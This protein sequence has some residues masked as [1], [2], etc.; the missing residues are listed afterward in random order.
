MAEYMVIE[1]FRAGNSAAVYAR[2]TEKGRMLPE[3]LDFVASWLSGRDDTC[4]QVMRT[5]TPES[6]D[7]WTR[8][9]D[10]LVDFEI[11]KL[12]EKQMTGSD[13]R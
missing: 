3:G 9:W 10:D 5:Q 2:F 11:I 13:N 4:W 12:K 7:K 6:F 1:R 8:H